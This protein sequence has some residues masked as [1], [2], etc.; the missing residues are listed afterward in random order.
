MI[1]REISPIDYTVLERFLY[2]AYDIL[3]SGENILTSREEIFEP[4]IYANIKDFGSSNDC[5]VVAE[6]DGI[7]VGAAWTRIIP[8]DTCIDSKFP[9]LTISVLPEYRGNGIGTKMMNM[10]FKLSKKR[11]YRKT[12]LHVNINNPAVSFY[13]RLGYK[14]SDTYIDP[15]DNETIYIMIKDLS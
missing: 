12:L 5:G 9:D 13:K 8:D 6:Q 14:I 1:I 10:L 7:I 15:D 4:D 11:G 3:P 2:H